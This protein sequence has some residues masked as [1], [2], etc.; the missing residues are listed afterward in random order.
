MVAVLRFAVEL[1]VRL[2]FDLPDLVDSLVEE[3]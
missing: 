2:L 1:A 3:D